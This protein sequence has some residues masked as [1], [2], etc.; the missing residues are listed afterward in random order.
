M[1]N[2]IK[3]RVFFN[4]I[5]IEDVTINMPVVPAI[6]SWIRFNSGYWAEKDLVGK[7]FRVVSVE[8][9]IDS[10]ME[11]LFVKIAVD[12]LNNGAND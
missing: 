7:D 8:Y 4:E 11:F 6:G 10:N 2:D 3:V 12:M 5:G 1:K 9:E